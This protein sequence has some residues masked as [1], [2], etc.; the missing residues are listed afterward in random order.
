MR[1]FTTRG[2]GIGALR[3]ESRAPAPLG[4]RD[5]R[6]AMR[7]V[8]LN[9]RDL[10]VVNGVEHWK[11]PEARVPASDGVGIVTEVGPRVTRVR[12]GDRVA[13]VFTPTWLDGP[14]SE[15][16][17]GPALGGAALDGVLAT[18]RTFDEQAV[19]RVPDHLDDA[20]ASTLPVAAVTAWHAVG[21]RARVA[22]GDVVLV[23][24]TGGVSLFA[25]QFI[26]ALGGRAIVTSSSETK[27]ERA[28][29]LGAWE[30]I[31]Y[32]RTPDWEREALRL[33][34]GRG[35]D[36]VVE[37]VGGEH[38]NRSL[39]AVRLSG[40]ISFIGLIAG[41][42]GAVDTYRFVMR[43]VTLH[44]IETG[45]RA[46]FDDMNAFIAAHGIRP[47]IDRAFPFEA[48]PDGLR[49]LEGGGHVGKVV[50]NA[51]EE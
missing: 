28:R 26:V 46:M 15:A 8:A 7:A 31:D 27:L 41:L 22:P 44:G 20:E 45:S 42:R 21:V 51:S 32:R 3:L 33:T 19:V 47:V 29:A 43:N 16:T 49:Y 40:T 34:D 13:G 5:V 24:G 11:P 4:A 37:V 12:V 14:L 2:D 50:V 9:Y 48:A 30:T 10:L 25:L 18:E 6:V 23:Q 35:V 36:Q 38:L 39:Q 17:A 1:A